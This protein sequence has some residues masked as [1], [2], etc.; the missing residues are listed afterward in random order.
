MNAG[1][2][3][4]TIADIFTRLDSALVLKPDRVVIM[5]G[6][7]DCKRVGSAGRAVSAAETERNITEL[8]ARL[9][10]ACP[11]GVV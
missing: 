10:T 8:H 6:A 4:D 1:I 3:A 5:V 9:S 2:P 11:D 7:N